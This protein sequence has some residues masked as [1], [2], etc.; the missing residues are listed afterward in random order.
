MLRKIE[1]ELIRINQVEKEI[2]T[3]IKNAPKGSLRCSTSRGYFQYYRGREYLNKDKKQVIKQ[4]A[5][6]EYCLSIKSKIAKVKQ[7]IELLIK[8]YK[9]EEL[10]QVYRKLSPV[11]KAV[12]SPLFKPIEEIIEEFEAIQY[13]GKEFAEQDITEYYTSKGERVRSKSE[14]IIAD[15]LYRCG[16]PYKYEM[17]TELYNWNKKV[18]I[19]PD[20]TVLN[21]RT[22]RRWIVENFGMMDNPTYYENAMFKLDT[23]EKNGI[24]LGD[25]LII[26]HETSNISLNTNVMKKYIEQY[27][28]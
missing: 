28:L 7:T 6:K 10:E 14:K 16:I 20:F 21:R 8:V 17:P 26:L 18:T 25:G 9:D 12:T 4:L 15:E 11:R 2:E 27:L 23:Y 24:L 13:N 19:Y 22:G 5:Q 1:E 3:T